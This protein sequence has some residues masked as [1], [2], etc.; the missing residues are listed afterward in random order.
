MKAELQKILNLFK[1]NGVEAGGVLPKEKLTAEMRSWPPEEKAHMRNAWHTMVGEGLIQEGN[2]A[3]PT[4]TRRGHQAVYG[5][6]P[7]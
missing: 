5:Q 2:P 6:A 3:G 7:D 4:L 1:E